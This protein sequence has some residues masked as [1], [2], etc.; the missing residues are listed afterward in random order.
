MADVSGFKLEEVLK[1]ACH[2]YGISNLFAEQKKA[3]VAFV[4][5]KDVFV[6]LP[7]G[8]GKSLIFQ[9]APFVH[10]ELAKFYPDS[11]F[12]QNPIVIVVSPLINLIE[13]Q[14]Q[15]LKKLGIAAASIGEEEDLREEME[16]H[17]VLR[18][19]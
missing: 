6:N 16:K 3:L 11:G 2:T 19:L 12:S 9:M 4:S 17:V 13:D 5:R 7:T 18:Y 1:K 14:K 15:H 8:F 10:A